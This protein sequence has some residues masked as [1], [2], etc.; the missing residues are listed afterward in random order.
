M[1]GRNRVL[2][3][4]IQPHQ[5]QPKQSFAR[6]TPLQIRTRLI[7]LSRCLVILQVKLS[8]PRQHPYA[9]L[10]RRASHQPFKGGHFID[11]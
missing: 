10:N 2:L 7:R 9:L 8:L 6:V 3:Q 4:V 1:S 11:D 5:A